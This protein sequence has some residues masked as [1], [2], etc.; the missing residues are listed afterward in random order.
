M[1]SLL[2]T[3]QSVPSPASTRK[4]VVVDGSESGTVLSV[5]SS[6]TARR[7]LAALRDGPKPVSEI[8]P[9]A[10]TSLQNAR[11]HVERLCEAE[12]VEP[13]DTWYSKKG[14]EMT[15]YGL[16]TTELVIRFDP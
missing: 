14:R 9:A 2:P 13:V 5:L 4:E 16:R 10:E 11:Y 7:I 1:A 8:A 6:Q 15:V 12:F 3:R